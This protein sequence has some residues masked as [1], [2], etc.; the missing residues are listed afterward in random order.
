[1]ILEYV[2]NLE[3]VRLI[4]SPSTTNSSIAAL[5]VGFFQ[6]YSNFEFSKYLTSPKNDGVE[7][8]E[9]V[10][11]LNNDGYSDFICVED[12]LDFCDLNKHTYPHRMHALQ[13]KFR[14]TYEQI[15]SNRFD[16]LFHRVLDTS[17]QYH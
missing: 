2:S 6:F 15:V 12:P 5:V 14:D 10:A 3:K 1:M 8:L 16:T 11:R 4:W 17:Q 13:Q 7:P 9:K